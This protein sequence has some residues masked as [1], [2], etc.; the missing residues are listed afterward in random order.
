MSFESADE[1]ASSQT[2]SRDHLSRKRGACLVGDLRFEAV[3][4]DKLSAAYS[5]DTIRKRDC[6]WERCG[7]DDHSTRCYW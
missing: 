2:I 7:W 1:I 6:A 3:F 4:T 5:A